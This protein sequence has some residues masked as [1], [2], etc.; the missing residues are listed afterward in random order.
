MKFKK[1][2]FFILA[3]MLFC[4]ESIINLLYLDYIDFNYN[5]FII[6]TRI[7]TIT[8]YIMTVFALIKKEEKKYKKEL[9]NSLK[10]L[11]CTLLI[12]NVFLYNLESYPSFV[13]YI[14]YPLSYF[15]YTILLY[16]IY[17]NS[18]LSEKKLTKKEKEMKKKFW[19]IFFYILIA[20]LI[21][22]LTFLYIV[23]ND[24]SWIYV[25]LIIN[26]PIIIPLILFIVT[27]IIKIKQ[28]K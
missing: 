18:I 28:Y 24:K 27:S 12:F 5:T 17:L 16:L 14:N 26:S 22:M 25:I 8:S 11:L 10:K 6:S 3:A 23:T 2:H 7:L 21:I 13:H 1:I 9:Y 19:S 15:I 20:L 4:L